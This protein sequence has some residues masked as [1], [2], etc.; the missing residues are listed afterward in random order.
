MHP[1]DHRVTRT[2]CFGSPGPGFGLFDTTNFAHGSLISRKRDVPTLDVAATRKSDMKPKPG[3]ALVPIDDVIDN[4]PF[5]VRRDHR[6]VAQ[7]HRQSLT[8]KN[9]HYR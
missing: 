4:L 6:I 8:F 5:I 7:G 1:D 3:T 9:I 2:R